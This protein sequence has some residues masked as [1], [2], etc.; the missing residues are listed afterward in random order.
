MLQKTSQSKDYPKK[1]RERPIRLHISLNQA[2][3]D[4]IVSE[5]CKA[6]VF[7]AAYVREMAF[8]GQLIS[9]LTDEERALFREM[10]DVSRNLN[11]LI[12]IAREQGLSRMLP[13]FEQY[14]NAVDTLLEKIKL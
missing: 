13:M 11:E 10:L 3:Y 5:S 6:G 14:R 1:I 9:R 12:K 7:R 4:F 2:E 8:R